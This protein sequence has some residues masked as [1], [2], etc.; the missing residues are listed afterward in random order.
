MIYMGARFSTSDYGDGAVDMRAYLLNGVCLNGMVRESLM[1]Q[2]HLGTRLPDN[3]QLSERT[4][5]LETET[6][7]SAT[8][9]FTKNLYS[10][11]NIMRQAASRWTS[12][13]NSRN[14]SRQISS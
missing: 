11:D 2:V 4:Y 10:R 3:L 8:K 6:T 1:K 14:S 7:V 5:A 9:D 12:T 13:T